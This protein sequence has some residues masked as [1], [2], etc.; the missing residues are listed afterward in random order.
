MTAPARGSG[1]YDALLTG[2]ARFVADVDV[3][4][5][6]HLV[7]VRSPVAHTCITA[8]ETAPAAAAPGVRGVF[9]AADLP[10]LPIWEIQLIP[11]ALAQPPLAV[12]VVRYVG[13]RV[14]AVVAES[15][16]AALDAAEL[17][18]VELDQLPV[19]RDVAAAVAPG[20]PVLFPEH[21]SNVALEWPSEGDPP[22]FDGSEI[23]V[24]TELRIPR[25]AVAPMEGHAALAV[26]DGDGSLA[27]WLSTQVPH[28]ARVQLARS[29]QMPLEAVRVIAP[30]VGGGF[31]GKA[32]G[33]IADHVVTAAAAQHLGRPVQFIEDRGANLA[34][35]HGRGVVL[36][37]ELHARRDGRVVGL[38]AEEL[39]DAGA[40]PATGSVEPGKT[41]LMAGGP[42]RIP[43]IEFTARSVMTNL[44]PTG[45]YRGPGRAEATAL[46][47]RSMDLLAAELDIDPVEVR[48]RNLITTDEYPYATATGLHYDS[49]DYTRLLDTVLERGDYDG[50]RA[51][52][53]ERR[54]RG[55]ARAG[56]L[57]GV[58][59]S[60]VVDST[61][62]FSRRQAA[63]VEITEAGDVEVRSATASAGQQHEIALRAVVDGV[64][65]VGA[66]RIHVVEGDTGRAPASDGSMGSRST[67][68]A[69]TAARLAAAEVLAKARRV[70]A[71]MLE[72]AE[73]DL[74]L[75]DGAFS[76]R[77]VPARGVGLSEVAI[78]AA[79]S[80]PRTP[81]T[82]ARSVSSRRA[83]SN[84]PTRRIRRPRTCPS[85]RSIPRPGA[86]R[87]S[88]T[89]P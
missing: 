4:D 83:C 17:V 54:D 62:W 10:M 63:T 47:E 36:R 82:T 55:D 86:S 33:G 77:G 32:H 58:G 78:R 87:R 15:L 76:V 6:L 39:C 3:A 2:A 68:L 66:D 44:A 60:V 37:G 14:V 16:A 45:A 49:G 59:L 79:S 28:G 73:D 61:A 5:R 24:R 84:S 67:Q 52:Q 27:V 80:T 18:V 81:T 74:V 29:L 40:Y 42:Y 88:G 69:G 12:D 65:P 41:R 9:T 7:F 53:R 23:V 34:T 70:A 11:E 38:R 75:L 21:G 43:A 30:H 19:V 64:L 26:P 85:S 48:R 13:E 56:P 72:A 20:A 35:M 57:L 31:G 71:T 1:R 50:W 8:I 51:R 25:L 89:W 22:G 46:L